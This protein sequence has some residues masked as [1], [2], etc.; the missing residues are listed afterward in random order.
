M[1]KKW[2]QHDDD[3]KL[4]NVKTHEDQLRYSQMMYRRWEEIGP[5]EPPEVLMDFERFPIED[6]GRPWM[7]P[8]Y[9]VAHANAERERQRLLKR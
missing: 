5:N 1:A 9:C 8:E 2:W 6:V 3:I 4:S 7:S